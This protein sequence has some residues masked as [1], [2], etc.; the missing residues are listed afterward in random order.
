M[1]AHGPST[2]E[3]SAAGDRA[4]LPPL[5]DFVASLSGE[6]RQGLADSLEIYRRS[7]VVAEE[8]PRVLAAG[9]PGAAVRI[10]EFTDVLCGHCAD[11]HQTM[12]YLGTLLPPG[13]YSL[14]TREFPLDGNCNPH[15][16]VRGPETVRCLAARAR[17]CLEASPDADELAAALYRNQQQLT[18]ELVFRLAAPFV[19]PDELARCTESAETAA[20]LAR[21]R[22]LRLEAPTPRHP[23]GAGQRP[24]GT[25]FRP[26]PLRHH[27]GAGRRRPPGLRRAAAAAPGSP[28]PLTARRPKDHPV[29]WSPKPPEGE[30][31]GGQ[32][33]K[34]R[35]TQDGG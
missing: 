7:P 15:L 12:E 24:P 10:T 30:S 22:R 9:S 16:Q 14:D 21:R 6:L 27:P 35:Q 13:S 11:L 4:T 31:R 29:G 25:S 20:K 32:G 23:P 5:E 26:L 1:A 3:T 17:I 19:D 33:P 18:P 34:Y 28:H 8:A 2:G